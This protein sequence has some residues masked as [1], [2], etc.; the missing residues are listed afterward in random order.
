M[1]ESLRPYGL[2]N[3]R[4]PCPSLSPRV[5]SNSCPLSQWCHLHISSSAAL[6]SF[7]H[8][9]FLALGSFLV[10][11]LFASG[12]QSIGASASVLPVNIQD[13]LPLGLTGLSPLE[14][15]SSTPQFKSINSLVLSLLHGPALTS[16]H[17]Y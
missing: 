14:E 3:S 17:D 12:D 10:N 16:I 8:Q 1:S 11:Q 7:C 9:S 2:Q 15:S 6:F 13:R 4:L 5:Y